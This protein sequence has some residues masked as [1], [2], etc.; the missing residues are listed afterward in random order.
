MIKTGKKYLVL[1]LD[2]LKEQ[3]ENLKNERNFETKEEDPH[4][5]ETIGQIK[6]I[7][8]LIDNNK[9]YDI[10]GLAA[11]CYLQGSQDEAT[12][13]SSVINEVVEGFLDLKKNRK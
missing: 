2:S 10:I 3:L 12:N 11:E 5:M 9:P 4:V 6:V 13:Q 7:K 8:N 1:N